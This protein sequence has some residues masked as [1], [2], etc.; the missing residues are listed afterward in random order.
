M[1]LES[2][3]DVITDGLKDLYNAENQLVKALPKMAKGA[4]SEELRNALTEHL[5]QTKNH[6]SRIEEACRIMNITPKGKTCHAMKG[7]IEEGSEILDEDGSPSAKDAAMIA[8]AQKVEHYEISAY[9]S[10]RTF[11]TVL[12][13][14]Q[15]AE[16]LNETLQEESEADK[17][18][19]QIAETGLNEEAAGEDEEGEDDEDEDEDDEEGEEEDDETEEEESET[20]MAS[21]RRGR[22][23]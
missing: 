8:A 17:K 22:N 12:G 21:T 2:L 1:H 18:L 6:V 19:T 3:R 9:G 14:N 16:L 13:E 7:L 23:S 11:A 10:L 20:D 15:L 4:G 5:E